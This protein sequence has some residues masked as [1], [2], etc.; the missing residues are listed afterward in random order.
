MRIIAVIPAYHEATRIGQTVARVLAYVDAAV[1]VDDGSTD[2]TAEEARAAGAVVV[3]HAINCGQGAG[4]RTGT[5]AAL[6][7]GAE[8]VVHV[9]A[10]GQ[11]DPAFVPA[12]V[13]PIAAGAADVTFGSR[14]LGVHAT[15]M[16]V[17]RNILLKMA[18]LFNAFVMGVPRTV[19]DPQSGLRAMTATA[20][21]SVAFKQDRMAHCSEILR[22]VTHSDL[23]WKEIPVRVS[24]TKESLSKGQKPTDA[25]N[26]VW[27]LLMGAF[28]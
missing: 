6:R 26:I 20:A 3:R 13:A 1:V 25:F 28:H 27:Q 22:L 15:G 14:F 18:R 2:G 8:I 4:L 16:S 9:D 7:L 17:G 10:D 12:L 19:T 11:H 5:E 24:Y 23:R 21:R